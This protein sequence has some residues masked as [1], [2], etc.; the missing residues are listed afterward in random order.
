MTKIQVARL[1]II[2]NSSLI[3]MKVATGI[4]SSSVSIISEAIH[5]TL[6]LFASI[7]AFIAIRISDTP[8][9]QEHPYGHGKYETVSGVIESLPILV[10]S[11]WIIYEAVHKVFRTI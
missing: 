5:S 4:I 7:I 6:D 1:S 3:L 8:P 11:I 2:S 9:D 10:A